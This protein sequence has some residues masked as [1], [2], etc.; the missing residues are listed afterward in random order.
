MARTR[1]RRSVK[2]YIEAAVRRDFRRRAVEQALDFAYGLRNR[3]RVTPKVHEHSFA[4]RLGHNQVETSLF[5][6]EDHVT[7]RC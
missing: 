6:W 2:S 3:E 7:S 1:K 4:K 5:R